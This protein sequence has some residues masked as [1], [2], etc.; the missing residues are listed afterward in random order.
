MVLTSKQMEYL[1]A[2]M[3]LLDTNPKTRL[4]GRTTLMLYV[5]CL[6]AIENPNVSIPIIDH[7]PF[8]HAN[9]D[10]NILR[11]LSIMIQDEEF[12]NIPFVINHQNR[13]IRVS[14]KVTETK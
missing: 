2:I 9:F 6:H 11:L 13:T 14:S 1:P 5:A 10:H 8:S 3:W 12:K 4:V 7:F